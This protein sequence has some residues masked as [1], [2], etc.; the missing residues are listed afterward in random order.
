MRHKQ[1]GSEERENEKEKGNT[2]YKWH[3][4]VSN[5]SCPAVPGISEMLMGRKKYEDGEMWLMREK[6]DHERLEIKGG[7][8]SVDPSYKPSHHQHLQASPLLV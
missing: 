6:E 8:T 7:P 3:L 4:F 5:P 2:A 1:Y